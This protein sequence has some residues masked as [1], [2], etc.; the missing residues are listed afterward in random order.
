[1][2]T[3]KPIRIVQPTIKHSL[4]I[5]KAVYR[6]FIIWCIIFYIATIII[7]FFDSPD[8][9]PGFPHAAATTAII[10][11]IIWG[12]LVLITYYLQNL[13]LKKLRYIFYADRMEY[14][15]GF[16]VKNRR[17]IKYKRITDI[18]QQRKIWERIYGLGTIG[19]NTAGSH[20]AEVIMHY[21]SGAD[22]IY[23]WIDTIIDE[24]DV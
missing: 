2:T 11:I 20:G 13:S 14:Y 4:L 8:M 17:T 9:K 15:D 5:F 10:A 23:D 18:I 16:L 12:S 21:L 22:E 24:K 19:I 3:E 6:T 1:M 7:T